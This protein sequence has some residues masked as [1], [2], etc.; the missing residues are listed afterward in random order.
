MAGSQGIPVRPGAVLPAGLFRA[1]Q[2]AVRLERADAG[3]VGGCSSR[4]V[5]GV[6]G[7]GGWP[8]LCGISSRTA[9]RRARSVF[10]SCV[11]TA[12]AAASRADPRRS[13]LGKAGT[14]LR[15]STQAVA[16]GL[17]VVAL[18]LGSALPNISIEEIQVA[19][20]CPGMAGHW[21]HGCSGLSADA[22][23]HLPISSHSMAA[24]NTAWKQEGYRCFLGLVVC[25]SRTQVCRHSPSSLRD[26]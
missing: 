10:A 12:S 23:T 17:A 20:L 18:R 4:G 11:P 3:P 24:S 14:G 16:M 5:A 7:V 6:G 21:H 22:S 15:C 19:L 1:L 25:G 2:A 13:Q 8:A 9:R 26:W